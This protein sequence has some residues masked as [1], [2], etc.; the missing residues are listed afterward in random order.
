MEHY[1]T[2]L[3]NKFIIYKLKSLH[4]HEEAILT[5]IIFF[6]LMTCKN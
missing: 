4:L 2:H 6:R 1:V 5:I 3:G